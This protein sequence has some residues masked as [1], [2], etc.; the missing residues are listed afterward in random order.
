MGR[1]HR[2]HSGRQERAWRAGGRQGEGR[3]QEESSRRLRQAGTGTESGRAWQA[4][5]GTSM[6]PQANE[7]PN[8]RFQAEDQQALTWFSKA[9]SGCWVDEGLKGGQD[10]TTGDPVEG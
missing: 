7:K 10:G 5:A 3:E 1:G 8:I 2:V 9:H 6:F 4:V